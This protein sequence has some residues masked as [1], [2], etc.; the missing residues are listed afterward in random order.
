M[1]VTAVIGL[2]W[3]DEGKGK[4]VD[5]LSQKADVV[6]RCQGGANAGHTMVIEGEK[7]VL[8]LVPSGILRPETTCVMGNGMAVD[9]DVLSEEIEMLGEA[10]IDV[11]GRL[12]MSVRAH[13][14]LPLHKKIELLQEE[15]RGD[16]RIGTTKRGIGPCYSD[17]YSRLGIRVGDI[18]HPD[19]LKSKIETL[20]AFHSGG[21]YAEGLPGVDQLM[22]YCLAHETMV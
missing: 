7:H 10:G 1:G 20:H 4:V 17:K 15:M 18:L 21:K 13:V 9:L 22:E 6:A 3:G 2:Q 14:V 16:G 8:H 12:L 19:T 5:V 11:S